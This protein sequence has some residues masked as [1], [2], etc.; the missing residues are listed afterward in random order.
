MYHG[1]LPNANSNKNPK[2]P[3]RL[4]LRAQLFDRAVDFFRS[5]P[6]GVLQSDNSQDEI[7]KALYKRDPLSAASHR[8]AD[9]SSLRHTR[10]EGT[11]SF[12]NVESRFAAQMC[13]LNAHGSSIALSSSVVVLWLLANANVSDLQRVPNPLYRISQSK[14][15]RHSCLYE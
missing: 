5:I 12:K 10:R 14:Y 13:R 1:S 9:F 2:K 11:E 3:R 8:F 15:N 6:L 4:T 7:I